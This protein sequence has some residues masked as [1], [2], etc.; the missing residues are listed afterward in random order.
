MAFFEIPN[1]A[2]VTDTFPSGRKSSLAFVGA[3]RAVISA[4][5][6]R[7][8]GFSITRYVNVETAAVA[9]TTMT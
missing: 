4:L 6:R 2:S 9:I 7:I 1:V 8:I 3:R 5:P